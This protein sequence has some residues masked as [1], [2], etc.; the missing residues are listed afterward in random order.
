MS[1]LGLCAVLVE[2]CNVSFGVLL[3]SAG[4]STTA[5][6]STLGEMSEGAL[7]CLGALLSDTFFFCCVRKKYVTMIMHVQRLDG[8]LLYTV[9]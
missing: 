2:C 5:D 7:A 1:F 6:D 8:I 9:V 3:L 4:G